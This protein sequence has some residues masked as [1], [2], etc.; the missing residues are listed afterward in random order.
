MWRQGP[1]PKNTFFWGGVVPAG[2]DPSKGFYFADFCGDHAK[3][4][5][6]PRRLEADEVGWYDN[7]LRLPPPVTNG[8]RR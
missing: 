8:G 7:C 2:D 3:I 4:V 1:L 6:G 5:P